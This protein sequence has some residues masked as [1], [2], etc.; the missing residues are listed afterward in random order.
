MR[1]RSTQSAIIKYYIVGNWKT[2]V[3]A[4]FVTNST[5]ASSITPER[6]ITYFI[7][8]GDQM[9]ETDLQR[10]V[11]DVVRER[12]GAA[13]KL[14]HRFAIGVSDLLVKL[15]DPQPT[16]A[17]GTK[18]N[19]LPAML[20]EVK[21]HE[22]V[23]TSP[24]PFKLDLSR[25]QQDFLRDFHDAGMRVGVLSF[26]QRNGKLNLSAAVFEL[27]SLITA[28]LTVHPNQHKSLGRKPDERD[29]AL[30]QILEDYARG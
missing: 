8:K 13:Y 26:L 29:R 9:L 30:Y 25:P 17:A 23:N 18:F 5:I 7:W 22:G 12:G 11:I 21:Q 3:F 19:R 16:L 28:G 24:Y 20:L 10:Y 6:N 15:I 4:R 27:D 2:L 1:F 14:S